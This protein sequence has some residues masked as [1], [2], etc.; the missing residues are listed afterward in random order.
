MG[1]GERDAFAA[2]D[3]T[4]SQ[5]IGGEG[6]AKLEH[7]ADVDEGRG[8]DFS[9]ELVGNHS[10]R[11]THRHAELDFGRVQTFPIGQS[12]SV[13]HDSPVAARLGLPFEGF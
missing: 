12:P 6:I 5:V 1:I 10:Y 9:V 13:L 2:K 8:A 7:P 3:E 4:A 11:A